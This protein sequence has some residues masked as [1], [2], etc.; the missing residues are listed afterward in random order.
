MKRPSF[1]VCGI[2]SAE[3][4]RAAAQA[5]ASWLGFNFYEPS[6]RYVAEERWREMAEALPALPKVA[7]LVDPDTEALAAKLAEGFDFAQVHFPAETSLDRVR[8]WSAAV[9]PGRL[10]LA[11]RLLAGRAFDERWLELAETFLW[12]AARPGAFGGTGQRSD[13]DGFARARAAWPERAWMLAGGLGP[14]NLLEAIQATGAER[15]DLNSGVESAPGVKD[16][17]RLRAVKALLG[18]SFH[19]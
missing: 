4:A 10:W 17:S 5:G 15:L 16:P 3:A 18:S 14:E 11:P 19:A 1:K 7:V 6:P 13:W 9:S 8:A 12:D 2:G